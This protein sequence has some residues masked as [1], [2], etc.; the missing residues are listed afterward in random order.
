MLYVLKVLARFSC[1]TSV[2]T[3]DG[4]KYSNVI[5]VYNLARYVHV[6]SLMLHRRLR[7]RFGGLGLG[8]ANTKSVRI[9]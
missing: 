8:G 5:N 7:K 4:E 6:F 1:A 2:Y 3:I 9:Y